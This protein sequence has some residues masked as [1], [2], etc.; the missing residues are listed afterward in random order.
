LAEIGDFGVGHG[1]DRTGDC[2]PPPSRKNRAPGT[3]G[4]RGHFRW[5]WMWRCGN[6]P[7]EFLS[8]G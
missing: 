2:F 1:A 7:C 3:P 5:S 8:W 4:S 6:S